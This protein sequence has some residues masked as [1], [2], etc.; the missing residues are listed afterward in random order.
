MT[1]RPTRRAALAATFAAT[2]A[3]ALPAARLGAQGT[4]DFEGLGWMENR[5]GQPVPAAARL[6]DHYLASHGVR[7]TS[8]AQPFV[9][10]VTLGVGH[11][12]SG[13]LGVGG[14][15]ALGQ[16]AY[17]A[18]FFVELFDPADPLRMAT[19]G[20]LSIRNDRH[21]IGGTMR[22]R[23]FDAFGTL[24]GAA[25]FDDRIGT[26]LTIALPGMH[27]V[28]VRGTR[29]TAFDDLAFGPLSP[30]ARVVPEP[31]PLALAAAGLVPLALRARRQ[32]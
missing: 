2:L 30:V 31:A 8:A 29:T 6:A 1:R 15:T 22:L 16:L 23:A 21:P 25:E 14:V 11:A 19:T 18:P 27:R 10:V 7:F 32:R 3:A 5:P 12:T 4:I 26:V 28:E 9:A 13:T 24:L 17:D 20:S